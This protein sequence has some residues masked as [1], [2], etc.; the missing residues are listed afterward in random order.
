[1]SETIGTF[2]GAETAGQMLAVVV[3]LSIKT[4]LILALAGIVTSLARRQSAAF[5]QTLGR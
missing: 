5:R 4:L 2:L 3:D 1:M